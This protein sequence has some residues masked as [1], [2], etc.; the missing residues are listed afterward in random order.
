[1]KSTNE[2]VWNVQL[3]AV[4]ATVPQFAQVW[5]DWGAFCKTQLWTK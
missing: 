3:S 2:G 4:M 5:Q 1:L